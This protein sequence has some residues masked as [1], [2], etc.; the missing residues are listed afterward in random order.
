MKPASR[1]KVLAACLGVGA[2]TIAP[3]FPPARAESLATTGAG[4]GTFN[5][6]N[7]LGANR[8]YA[9]GISGQNSITFNLEAG[10]FWN[11][12]ETL[13]HI[14]TNSTNFVNAGNTFGGGLIAPLYDRHATLVASLIGGRQSTLNPQIRQQGIAFGT[15]LRSAAIATE[16]I[17][18]AYANGFNAD[19][20]TYATAYSAAF[21]AAQV[22]NSS[23]GYV[24][25]AASNAFT[26]FT[27][28]LAVANAGTLHVQAAGNSGPAPN[29]VQ[30]PGSGYNGL[31]VGALDGANVFN[32]VAAFSSRAPQDFAY[33]SGATIVR[34]EGVRAAVDLAAPGTAITA[35]FYGGRSGGNNASLAGST[36]LGSVANAY[37]TSVS[38]T[39]FAA[40]LVA[41]GA[42]LI[43]SAART[44][45]PLA[46]NAAA[47]SSMVVKSIL[48]SG[49]D[50]TA[51]WNN[52]QQVVAAGADSFVQTTQSLDWAVGAGRMNLDRSFDIQL[53]GQ[54][55]VTGI[56]TGLLG[57]VQAVGWDYGAAQRGV[58][59]DY[60]L[61]TLLEGSTFTAT[62]SWMRL[63]DAGQNDLAQADLDFSLWLLDDNDAFAT[64]I[65][66][67]ASDYNTVEHLHLVLP[68]QGRYGMR[69]EY[70]SNTFDLTTGG[71]WGTGAN[72][73]T[74]GLAW[75]G[76]PVPVP[77]PM[78]L[79]GAMAAFGWAR[80]LRRRQRGSRGSLSSPTGRGSA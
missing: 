2:A 80:R 75:N 53:S 11:G 12:H 17:A 20:A 39:S 9:A 57:D 55:D 60:L 58:F 36:D 76:T 41:G 4:G 38:G 65:G 63:V 54:T 1:W 79:A 26:R 43:A 69:V 21:S 34:T 47:A 77:G 31:T 40:P 16:W 56:A 73:Q 42:A 78:P 48:L 24:D 45:Q 49:A 15:D 28:A 70:L 74:Y 7:F 33:V 23:Y 71:V 67:S 25:P 44:L 68:F 37:S 18:P 29:T 50:K 19:G 3:A 64:L 32:S 46:S 66:R 13:Q 8:Y 52:G 22:I 6:N 59:N 10:H 14:A 62:L 61:P 51:G 72:L 35:A 30:A 27:D 5:L